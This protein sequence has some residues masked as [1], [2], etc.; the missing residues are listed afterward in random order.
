MAEMLKFMRKNCIEPV[1][2]VDNNL[3]ESLMRI[4]DCFFKDYIESENNKVTDED[5]ETLE[6]CTE[7]LFIFALTWSIGTTTNF[8]GREKFDRKLRT[9]IPPNLGF[10][11]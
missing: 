3:V 8:E 7:Q 2:T 10:P 4:L 6:A 11:D 9:L 5:L 1:I